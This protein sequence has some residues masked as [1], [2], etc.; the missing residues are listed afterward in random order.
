M[1]TWHSSYH[2]PSSRKLAAHSVYFLMFGA[3][4][5][6]FGT[7]IVKFASVT[8]KSS[9]RSAVLQCTLVRIVSNE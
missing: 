5:V 3:F 7:S 2:E 4:S 9:L 8:E 1:P 6:V